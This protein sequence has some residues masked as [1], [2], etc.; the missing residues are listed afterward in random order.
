MELS[1]QRFINAPRSKVWTALQSAQ[2]LD[3]CL[4][5]EHAVQRVSPTELQVGRPVNGRVTIVQLGPDSLAYEASVG[6]LRVTLTE[7]SPAMTRLAY[8]LDAGAFDTARTQTQID[9]LVEAFQG[10]VSGPQE[11]AAG[12]LAGVQ[13]AGLR[14]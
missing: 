14:D 13:D 12:G 6:R 9:Q 1:G 7:E 4:K 2:T 3:A 10:Q 8:T 11:I 5:Q